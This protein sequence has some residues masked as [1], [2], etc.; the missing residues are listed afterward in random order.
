MSWRFYRRVQVVPGLTLNFSKSG[1]SFS[2]G[3]RGARYTIGARGERLTFGIPGTGLFYT[4]EKRKS[5]GSSPPRSSSGQEFAETPPKLPLGFFAKRRTPP[6]EVHFT[7]ACIS[8][9]E[10]D[11]EAALAYARKAAPIPDAAFLTAVLAGNMNLYEDASEF[12]NYAIGHD[13]DIGKT[14]RKYGLTLNL[15]IPILNDEVIVEV[16]A[17]PAGLY[18]VAARMC[19]EQSMLKE[20]ARYLRIHLDINWDKRVAVYLAWLLLKSP[21]LDQKRC[22]EII[23]MDES[24]MTHEVARDAYDEALLR[25]MRL[26]MT[27]LLDMKNIWHKKPLQH[28]KLHWYAIRL[29]IV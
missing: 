17:D 20:A 13:L 19:E 7:E 24:L 14:F 3:G 26:S 1:V 8:A 5:H 21:D 2:F 15:T 25:M 23:R 27:R 29:G 11:Y 9:R 22:K 18:L 28:G 10:G 16:T 6:E 12:I 4:H